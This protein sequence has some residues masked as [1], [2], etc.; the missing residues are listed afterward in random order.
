GAPGPLLARAPAPRAGRGSGGK[1]PRPADALAV[2]ATA[3]RAVF[4]VTS[5]TGIGGATLTLKSGAWPRAVVLRLKYADGRPWRYL[6]GLTLV[7]GRMQARGSMA[8]TGKLPFVFAGADGRFPPDTPAAGTWAVTI[9]PRDGV[10]EVV[11]PPDL[12]TG[13]KSVTVNWVDLY[14]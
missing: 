3:D 12:C 1:R 11:L 9:R 10:M 7:V 4:T 6:E 2:E 8:D 13:E 5:R 14:R